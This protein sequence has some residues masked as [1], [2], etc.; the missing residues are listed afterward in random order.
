VA[1]AGTPVTVWDPA[2]HVAV[3]TLTDGGTATGFACRDVTRLDL[4]VN[5]AFHTND[6]IS[7]AKNPLFTDPAF[8][9]SWPNP[10]D[11]DRRWHG[12]GTPSRGT[13]A[14][15][16]YWPVY[17]APLVMPP[18]NQ[19]LIDYTAPAPAGGSGAG[20]PGCRYSG[21]TRIVFAGTVMRVLSPSTTDAPPRCLDVSRRTQEQ[22]V[23]IPAL[24]YVDAAGV[25]CTAG[26]LGYPRAGED[27]TGQTTDYACGRG[28]ALVEGT[29]DGRVTVASRDDIL[30][31]G[32]L[33]YQDRGAGTDML[34]L[35]ADNC[36]WVYHPV[37]AAGANLLPVAQMVHTVQAV[38]MSVRHSY[39][40]QN[41]AKG[42]GVPLT[43]GLSFLGSIVQRFTGPFGTF[44]PGNGARISGIPATLTYDLRLGT[45][46][47]PYFLAPESAAWKVVTVTDG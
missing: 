43:S 38:V 18:G 35:I 40:L 44:N 41:W 23:P 47:P 6:A 22:I 32:D 42:A 17:A 24:I 33:D 5:G 28:T 27:T 36:V 13:P 19:S 7:I 46:Q 34:G 8:E 10:P 31:I 4:T 30:I 2:R 29:L 9:S 11:P 1:D 45:L 12:T 21:A 37:T 14:R 25:P 16:G 39:L 3:Q 26:A 15:P 20:R